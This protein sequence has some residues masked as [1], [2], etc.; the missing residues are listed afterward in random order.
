MEMKKDQC[1]FVEEG[2]EKKATRKEK[3]QTGN[4]KV[5]KRNSH[6][7]L[8]CVSASPRVASP[9]PPFLR[10]RKEGCRCVQ[11]DGTEGSGGERQKKKN[12]N[13]G[14]ETIGTESY[15]ICCNQIL[16]EVEEKIQL[17][18]NEGEGR[19]GHG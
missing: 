7:N 16:G 11:S 6:C 1:P 2:R 10:P 8:R 17:L 12:C 19:K 18:M 15:R 13:R 5:G 9:S 3:K 14:K 4:E